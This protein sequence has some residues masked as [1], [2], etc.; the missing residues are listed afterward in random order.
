MTFLAMINDVKA[1]SGDQDTTR[2]KAAINN[3]YRSVLQKLKLPHHLIKASTPIVL[4]AGTQGYALASDFKWM[5]KVWVVDPINGKPIYLTKKRTLLNT[6]NQG[7]SQFYRLYIKTAGTGA[8]RPAWGVELE[9]IPNSAFVSKYTSLYYEYYQQPVDLSANTDIPSIGI[10]DDQ[11]IVYGASV[12]L[13]A[14]QDD[15]AGFQMMGQM[16]TD[17][18]ADLIQRA[19]EMFGDDVIVGP[20]SEITEYAS[21]I[22]DDY[23]LQ[24]FK[25][26]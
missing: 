13:N 26:A 3:V 8:T 14:K 1:Y 9:D 10:G 18:V 21:N 20:G 23:G 24:K 7:T 15:T 16:Y 17:G 22:L 4:V 11:V 5:N 19:V 12:L 25:A 6:V 2:I